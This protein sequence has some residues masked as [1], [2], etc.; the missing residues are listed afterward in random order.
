MVDTSGYSIQ[1]PRCASSN[2]STTDEVEAS[3]PRDY[4]PLSAVYT[5]PSTPVTAVYQAVYQTLV[6]GRN[7]ADHRIALWA[8]STGNVWTTPEAVLQNQ[9]TLTPLPDPATLVGDT[10]R[11]L[12]ITDIH[13]RSLESVSFSVIRGDTQG[14]IPLA[15]QGSFDPVSGIFTI[16]AAAALNALGGGFSETR[17]DRLGPIFTSLQGPTFWWSQ[18]DTFRHRILWDGSKGRWR[19]RSGSSIVDLGSFTT[20]TTSTR[21]SPGP[22][23]ISLGDYLPGDQDA[24]DSWSMLRVG[25]SPNKTSTPVAEPPQPFGGVLVVSEDDYDTYDFTL[26]PTVAGVLRL[27]DYT[28]RWN[29][30]YVLAHLGE[31][32]YYSYDDFLEDTTKT[33]LGTL[34]DDLYLSP[35]PERWEY[36]II[37]IGNHSPLRARVVDTETILESLDLLEGEVGVARSTGKV[38]ISSADL[39]KRLPSES[40]FD[41]SYLDADVFYDGVSLTS[42]PVPLAKAIQLVDAGG[43]PTDVSDFGDLYIPL[44]E[45]APTPGVS[46]VMWLPDET[47]SQPSPTP[48]PGTRPNG[49]GLTRSIEGSWDL[50]LFTS[51]GVLETIT[52]VLEDDEIPK[53]KFKIPQGTALVDL[54][55]GP[56]NGSAVHLGRQDRRKY[57]GLAMYFRQ[58]L[59]Y[60]A[61]YA[62]EAIVWS[63]VPGPYTF[64]GQESFQFAINGQLFTWSPPG[65]TYTTSEVADAL[66]SL[67]GKSITAVH[68]SGHVGIHTVFKGSS[69]KYVGSIEIGGL[70]TADFRAYATLGFGPGWIVRISEIPQSTDLHWIPATGMAVGV[71]RS[72]LNLNGLQGIPDVAATKTVDDQVLQ[73]R[74][75]GS[76]VVLL[77]EVPLESIPGYAQNV[78][79]QLQRGLGR[80]SLQ[81]YE[82]LWYK[83]GEGRM[84]WTEPSD[85][86]STIT[87]AS[88]TFSFGVTGVVPPALSLPSHLL[89]L[90]SPGSSYEAQTLDEDY[91]LISEGVPGLGTKIL[92]IGPEITSGAQGSTI[93][94][95][96]SDGTILNWNDFGIVAGDHLDITQGPDDLKGTY[97]ITLVT[98]STLGVTPVFAETADHLGWSIYGAQATREDGILADVQYVEFGTL[99][100]ETF[101]IRVL[102]KLGLVS[103]G[104][105]ASVD[106]AILRDREVSVRLGLPST[107]P[108]RSVTY[109][110]TESLGTVGGTVQGVPADGHTTAHAYVVK[111]G[112]KTYSEADGNL[113]FVADLTPNLQGDLIEIDEDGALGLGSTVLSDRLGSKIFYVQVFLPSTSVPEGT[114]ECDPKTGSLN[115][116]S[117]DL[118]AYASTAAYFVEELQTT[119]GVDATLNP[120]QGSL[121]LAQPLRDEQI[122]E[123]EYFLAVQGSGDLLLTAS[124]NSTQ[125]SPTQVIEFLP[126]EVTL[127]EATPNELGD[128]SSTWSFNPTHRTQDT[129][130]PTRIYIDSTLC[131]IGNSPKASILN[132]TILFRDP[133]PTTSTVRISYGVYESFGGEQSF[134]VTQPPV[135][136]PPLRIEAGATFFTLVGDRT[137]DIEVD[138]LLRVGASCFYITAV[139][140]DAA[141]EHTIVDIFPSPLVEVGSR[142]PGQNSISVITDRPI[143]KDTAPDTFWR[144]VDL[145]FAP[146]NRG[147][148]EITFTGD[149]DDRGIVTGCLLE[150]GGEPYIIT[151]L[152][153]DGLYTT[154]SIGSAFTQGFATGVDAVRISTRPIYPAESSLF[155]GKSP[156]LADDPY[157]VLR[158][159]TTGLG[160]AQILGVEALVD[161]GSGAVTLLQQPLH[162]G[163]SL[164]LRHTAVVPLE[165]A[166][167]DGQLQYPQVRGN[168]L[169]TSSPSLQNGR[170]GATLYAKFTYDSPDTWMID[171][172][173]M[174]E[175]MA[176]TQ[177]STALGASGPAF[178]GT[179]PLPSAPEGVLG[180]R[181]EIRDIEVTD[182]AA[183]R[184][185]AFYHEAISDLEQI[186]ETL[187]GLAIGDHDGKFR[188]TLSQVLPPTQGTEDP[189]SGNW[190]PRLIWAEILQAFAP[191]VAFLARDPLVDPAEATLVADQVVGPYIDSD[192]LSELM[193]DQRTYIR[194]DIDDVVLIGRTKKRLEIQP[195][196]LEAFGRYA[197]M[198]EAHSF[199]RL[200]PERTKAFTI[201]DPGLLSDLEAS[202]PNPG[203]YAF[204]KKVTRT[205]LENGVVQVAKRASTFNLPVATFENPVLGQLTNLTDASITPRRARARVLAYSPTG[206]P[207]LDTAL[208]TAGETTFAS[209]PRPA[210]LL[211]MVP[212]KEFPWTPEG[213]PDIDRL[214]AQGGD[215]YDLSS[216][217]PSLSTP[218]WNPGDRVAWGRHA[219]DVIVDLVSPKTVSYLFNTIN[220]TVTQ[221]I[222]VREVMLGCLVTFQDVDENPILSPFEIRQAGDAP[223]L[224][225]DVA[226]FETGDSLIVVPPE[227][228]AIQ[229]DVNDPPTQ[230]ERDAALAGLGEYRNNFDLKIRRAEGEIVDISLPSYKDPSVLGLKEILGQ[231]PLTPLQEIEAD[232]RFRN[233]NDE[234]TEFPA[235]LGE[236]RMDSGDLG[237]PYLY[238]AGTELEALG[239]AQAA[240]NALVMGDSPIPSAVYPDEI[241]GADGSVQEAALV[242]S[243]ETLPVTAQGG[244]YTPHSGIA[245]LRAWDYLL[246]ET[247]QSI[248]AG[249][250]G[251]L[252]VGKVES[253]KIHPPRFISPSALG[254]RF[255]YQ[256]RSAISFVLQDLIFNP[257]GLVLRRVGNVTQLDATSISQGILVFNDGSP[258]I[259]SGGLNTIFDPGGPF[260][261]GINNDNII[262]IHLWIP[263]DPATYLQAIEIRGN[264]NAPTATGDLGAQAISVV[265]TATDELIEVTTPGGA[266]VSIGAGPPPV[267]PEDPNNPG[268]TIPLWFTIDIDTS[269]AGNVLLPGASLTGRILEDRVSFEESL[270]LRTVLPRGTPKPD[271]LG[272]DVETTLNVLYVTS[273]TTDACTVNDVSEINGGVPFTVFH[274]GSFRNVL[275]GG[276]G[277]STLAVPA[278]E[279]S[280]NTPLAPLEPL[281]F[282]G[283]PSSNYN[284]SGDLCAGTGLTGTGSLENFRI[285]SPLVT[286][287]SLTDI[288][289]GDVCVISGSDDATPKATTKAG[290]YIVRHRIQANVGLDQRQSTL[291]TQG[292]PP[293]GSA[294]VLPAFPTVTSSTIGQN[295]LLTASSVT[296]TDGGSAWDASGTLYILNVLDPASPDYTTKNYKIDY[297]SLNLGTR[298]FFVDQ[299]TATDF[300]GVL[301]AADAVVAID[302]STGAVVA[303]M[304][305][306]DVRMDEALEQDYPRNTVGYNHAV[307]TAAGFLHLRLFG[308]A[309]DIVSTFGGVTPI[310][311]S[312]APLPPDGCRIT[313]PAASLPYVFA[314]SEEDIVYDGV[315]T[316]LELSFTAGSWDAIHTTPGLYAMM[317]SDYLK[318]ED[319]GGN[320][321]HIAQAGIFFEPSTPR[322]TL[323]YAGALERVVDAAHA[324]D[325]NTVGFRDGPAFGEASTEP[326]TFEI[327]RVRRWHSPLISITEA[328]AP[329]AFSYQIRRGSVLSYGPDLVGTSPALIPYVIQ[330]VS[331]TQLGLLTDPKVN[332]HTGDIFRVLD[333]EGALVEE[334]TIA[335]V[336][337][338]GLRLWLEAPG[339]S[340]D[341]SGAS[342]EIYLRTPPVPQEQNA[343]EL[344]DLATEQI[345]LEK[346]A[347][348]TTEQGGYVPLGDL[349]D[350]P[351]EL[352]DTDDTLDFTSFSIQEGDIIL[353]DPAGDVEGPLGV[354]SSGQ[355]RGIRPFGDRSVPSRTVAQAGQEVP[356][357]AGGPSELDDN[358]GWYRIAEVRQ[359]ALVVDEGTLFTG[360]ETQDVTFGSVI[361][362]TVYPTISGSMATFA[363]PPGGP[364]REAQMTLRPTAFAGTF[365]SPQ[366]SFSG[367][368]FSIAPLS[369]R[370][371]R[372]SSIF[373]EE[374]IDTILAFRERTLSWIELM[375]VFFLNQKSGSYFVF[376]RDEHIADLGSPTVVDEGKGVLSNALIDSVRG[377]VNISPF[378]NTSDA[379]SVLDRRFWGLD[380]RLDREVPPYQAGV[381]SY[382][383]FEDAS[384]VPGASEGEGR[385]VLPD[386]ILDI[387]DFRDRLRAYRMAWIRARVERT[388]G[389]L[390]TKDRL[391]STLPKRLRERRDLL[392]RSKG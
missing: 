113:L 294:F 94:N 298:R 376:Q 262:R 377:L 70:E 116:N 352:R 301:P 28:L 127:E 3:V 314:P 233:G 360:D 17:G 82:A 293:G 191:G 178:G 117:A 265:P 383:A 225:G 366:D 51:T 67:V 155:L 370:V 161:V 284:E 68:P 118:T 280:G 227:F 153:T 272:P 364:G 2:L 345:L 382:A 288:V 203:V 214:V 270:D 362:Y 290:T 238:L 175:V 42:T 251:I 209:Q 49:S 11:Y 371:F 112:S 388:E 359:N 30:Q 79:F 173:P 35:V 163:E 184:F 4:K 83:F 237:L 267:L 202:P 193:E 368:L 220:Y 252:G 46:G 180:L 12:L 195:L 5:I 61:Y 246:V 277:R 93:G 189:V 84:L 327:R 111:V 13:D 194:N 140:Y 66:D 114:V 36:P 62:S 23:R 74:V 319:G 348:Y 317:P 106:Q 278:Y 124:P 47:G 58:T 206:F 77:P 37:R 307:T 34:G 59:V 207:E 39:L 361:E 27:S 358:R 223:F 6:L 208:A 369:Y 281:T 350:D 315:P 387:L 169:H 126:L 146:I 336:D 320:P 221:P 25:T 264:I 78:Y 33:P 365:G 258:G 105:T 154:I 292:I 182:Q 181:G 245:D 261:W 279:G 137:T 21:L 354:P 322:P 44:A 97:T 150:I 86:Q 357:I 148:T 80:L 204:R 96:F 108:S 344:L 213:N 283:M 75:A 224:V 219:D 355:E 152:T 57:N 170:L 10:T 165:P 174:S 222:F 54:R 282:A 102:S 333:A 257:P 347:D 375:Q 287:G 241:L 286:L 199:S 198:G 254:D 167:I 340:Q 250:M 234:P 323:D 239:K 276:D 26:N 306:Y 172:L 103:T 356:F 100:F 55:A 159:D 324:L 240:M 338:D 187:S 144:D 119:Q 216:G 128:T 309:G 389:T 379:V 121:A 217:D 151:D 318:S 69:G 104:L 125:P 229:T 392:L 160:V 205:R 343:A 135:W 18:N 142:N 289:A 346:K 329:L 73:D 310:V 43:S 40:T 53:F 156:V 367:N 275:D 134:T 363:D 109:L 87:L 232:V 330:T 15:G 95:A 349:P 326:V 41:I 16:V 14:T 342:F 90:A 334:A 341:P 313:S 374:A 303:G 101:Q 243:I 311:L 390:P 242:T 268:Q 353:I 136:R 244:V 7:D 337:E 45:P 141:E 331:G 188:F 186:L 8:A 263:G 162:A 71:R 256:L 129:D 304:R 381:P 378:A 215:L 88:P 316:I 133:V 391:E 171:V 296:L 185:L 291:S 273:K 183:R 373:T 269:A 384:L 190:I 211:S 85:I 285:Q 115:F 147:Y 123:V 166:V 325:L 130:Y 274:G 56:S 29:P 60:P 122:V 351:R 248:N 20:E 164:Y 76:S 259:V 72:P 305:S 63:S 143:A 192:F 52:T 335:G 31:T 197:R 22:T 132:S 226:I 249:A 176:S 138:D 372:P 295:N 210:L 218:S 81:P 235:L 32:L 1:A 230:E 91:T 253:G 247:G 302:A 64:T 300:A 131:N 89:Y 385:P 110:L 139:T 98:S 145:P 157:T 386:H 177:T 107:S 158:F 24:P 231:N 255:R 212:W 266:F 236:S 19:P 9:A 271:P 332:I 328:L 380:D 120:I 196:R 201:T 168:I 149:F 50:V 312:P 299:T 179:I 297:L 200:Y 65:G 260:T 48:N 308:N 38:L 92:Q 99:P 228:K 339:L 321:G